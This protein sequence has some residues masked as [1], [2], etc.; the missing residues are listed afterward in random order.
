[1]NIWIDLGHIP[2]FNFYKVFIQKLSE[3]GHNVYV[4]VLGRGRMPKIVKYEL[5][6]LPNVSI[7]VI[8]KHRMKKWS[9]I[10]ETNLIRI[11]KLYFWSLGKHIDIAFSNHHQTSMVAKL[12]CIPGYAFG[13]DTQTKLY[14]IFVKYATKSH[15]LIY[16]ETEQC[17]I[18]PKDSLVKCLKEWAYLSPKYFKSNI[19]VLQKYGVKPKEY[20]FLRE[21]SVGTMNYAAQKSGAV[22][23]IKDLI[24]KNKKVLLSLEEKHRRNEYP[25]DWILL[26]EPIDDIHSLIYYSAGLVSSGDSMAREAALLG[27]PSYYLGVRHSMPAN[28]AAHKVAGLQNELSMPFEQWVKTL[29]VDVNEAAI[30]QEKL[31]K[32]IDKEFIDINEYMLS[33]VDEVAKKKQKK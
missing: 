1:M 19:D 15:M 9:A 25:E 17:K 26:Q 29:D 31:R 12:L 5:Q 27:V 16:E 11:P 10:L 21:V 2:Q 13:D 23:G 24:P 14:P 6:S 33:L 32:H 18:L 7:E 3:A 28:A 20:V 4:T 30:K 8:G 22:L